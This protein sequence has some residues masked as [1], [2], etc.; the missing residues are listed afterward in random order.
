M[1]T[2]AAIQNLLITADDGFLSYG[3][4]SLAVSD[5]PALSGDAEQIAQAEAIRAEAI[6]AI[7]QGLKSA[8]FTQRAAARSRGVK[9]EVA[10]A[11]AAASEASIAR[12]L[13]DKTDAAAWIE[14]RPM[15][16]SI[17]GHV[18]RN[19]GVI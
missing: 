13:G 19:N 11:R 14:A 7:E 3:A 18:A 4:I 9:A 16:F 5:L 17:S 1:M 2:T 15:L 6:Q 8:F 12:F 10:Q